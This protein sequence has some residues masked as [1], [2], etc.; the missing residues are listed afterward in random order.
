VFTIGGFALL[1]SSVVFLK[2]VSVLSW[3][4]AVILTLFEFVIAALQAYVFLLLTTFYFSESLA[5]G[6]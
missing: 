4:L 5:E 2:P 6:H 1:G 3:A